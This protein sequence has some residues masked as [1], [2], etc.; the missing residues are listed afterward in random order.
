MSQ[1]N[2]TN[3]TKSNS[4]NDNIKHTLDKDIS[5]QDQ[6]EMSDEISEDE[7][8]QTPP[9]KGAEMLTVGNGNNAGRRYWCIKNKL[10]K[11]DYFSWVDKEET[12]GDLRAQIVRLRE[13]VVELQ[14]EKKMLMSKLLSTQ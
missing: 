12:P 14:E 3:G 9:V 1:S 8:E 5:S 10:G 2:K 7:E 6:V 11:F 13:Q 4:S